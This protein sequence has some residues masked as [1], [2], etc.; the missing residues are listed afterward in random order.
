MDFTLFRRVL[1]CEIR[2]A[3]KLRIVLFLC[4]FRVIDL[5]LEL[6]GDTPV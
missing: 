2:K 6:G 3:Q 4:A 1:L 5:L